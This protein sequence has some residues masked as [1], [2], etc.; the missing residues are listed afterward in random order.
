MK[1]SHV[2]LLFTSDEHGYLKPAPRLQSEVQQARKDNPEGT[3]LISSGDMF[4]GAVETGVLGL[5]P[6][7]QL[8]DA[9]GYDVITLGNHDFDRGPDTARRWAAD[10]GCQ[11][12][13]ANV[14]DSATGALLP[15]TQ[16]SRIFELNG[17]KMGLIGVTTADTPAI[18][19]A[20]KTQGL[21]FSD[22]QQAVRE[23]VE[24]LQAQGV[25]LIGV[26]SHLG[27]PADRKLAAGVEGVDF[28]LGGHTHD[29]LEKPEEVNGTLIAHPGCF[30]QGMGRLDIDVDSASGQLQHADYH[31][32]KPDALP[33][34]SGH[35]RQMVDGWEQTVDAAM[36]ETVTDLQR[37]YAHDPQVLNGAMD[38]L[39]TEAATHATGAEIVMVNHKGIRAPLNSGPITRADVY[40]VFP[41]DNRLVTVDM[42]A[43][44]LTRI[45]EESFRRSDPT[46]L[47][48]DGKTFVA[49]DRNDQTMHLYQEVSEQEARDPNYPH[50]RSVANHGLEVTGENGLGW[51]RLDDQETVK[52]ATVDYLLQ[53]GLRYFDGSL[54][55][56]GDH[57]TLRDVLEGY[58]RNP[59][60]AA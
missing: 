44:E 13:L 27:L 50:A 31:L 12:L 7:Q 53:G 56:E 32:V 8:L 38:H 5:G 42:K 35:V 23:E 58:L 9:A 1:T 10:A 55:P 51:V 6:S 16:A 19:P 49:M 25:N 54:S 20:D 11:V 30:R 33:T 37:S 2:T 14:K 40:N 3:L 39:V 47:S 46:S 21:A 28:I 17:V 41:F 18:L 48:A 15:N 4:E 52:V 45:Y 26:V 22:P 59:D 60:I 57:G 43:G 36:G 34:T 29:A 24:K